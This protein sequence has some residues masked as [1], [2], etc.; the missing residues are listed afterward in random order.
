MKKLFN[1]LTLMLALNFLAIAGGVGY[2][3][4]TKRLTQESIARIKDVLFA[5]PAAAP[6]TQPAVAKADPTT[7]PALRLEELLARKSGQTA[8]EQ[9][10][11]IQQ[12]FDSQMAVL[13]RRQREIA[14]QQALI[15]KAKAQLAKDREDLERQRHDLSDKQKEAT[16][17]AED[18]GFQD[19]LALY[20]TLSGK[21]VKTIFMSLDDATIQQYLQAMEPRASA[22]IVKEFK[23]PEELARIQKV[24]ERMRISQSP[25]NP[26][27]GTAS[28]PPTASAA[29]VPATTTGP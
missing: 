11:F 22:R 5:A 2:L 15:A 23:T 16:R 3:V 7:Q 19:S 8:T 6:T 9:V 20:N 14:D 4:Q 29:N 1:V 12:A 13:D 21:Q 18:K 26:E 24:L 27:T 17:L 28:T 25:A 10:Q